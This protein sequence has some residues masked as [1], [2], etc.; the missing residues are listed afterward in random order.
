MECMW[1]W[2]DVF[3]GCNRGVFPGKRFGISVRRLERLDDL[4]T[5]SKISFYKLVWGR[6]LLG[7]GAEADLDWRSA[8]AREGASERVQVAS[9]I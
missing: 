5:C 2:G 1:R 6:E 9:D 8:R 3:V 7:I 4:S